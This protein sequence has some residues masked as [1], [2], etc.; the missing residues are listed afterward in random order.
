MSESDPLATPAPPRQ[1]PLGRG[2]AAA[3][4]AALLIGVAYSLYVI[5]GSAIKPGEAGGG[6]HDLARGSMAKLQVAPAAAYPSAAF[7]DGD[8][9]PVHM[10]DLRGKVVVLNLWATWCDPCIKEMPTLAKLQAAYPGRVQ[11]VALSQDRVDATDKAKAFIAA[12]PPLAFYQDAGFKVAPEI[13]PMVQGFP[14]TVLFDRSGVER[15][16]LMGEADWSSPEAR[17]VVDRVLAE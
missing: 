12:H 3:I 17:A 6:L 1:A 2:P 8:G 14:T 15:A 11:V 10:A 13:T 9:R 5:F 7:V 16:V 4:G